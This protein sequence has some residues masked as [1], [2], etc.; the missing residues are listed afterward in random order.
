MEKLFN[1]ISILFGLIGGFIVSALGGWDKW[2]IALIAFVILD[3]I[4]G[5]LKACFAKSLSSKTGAKGIVKKVLIFVVVGVAV[6]LQDLISFPLRDIVIL[7]Y[8][9]NEGLS[10]I[11]NI[12][13]FIPLPDKIKEVLLQLREKG[14]VQE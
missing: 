7:F 3:F 9:C 2:L 5:W 13:E 6:V 10:L 11:E 8:L 1:G 14:D 4:T 12:A